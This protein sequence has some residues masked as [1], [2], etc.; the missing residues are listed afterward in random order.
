MLQRFLVAAL[1]QPARRRPRRSPGSRA[2]YE[3]LPASIGG[4]GEPERVWGQ[5]TTANFFDV[6]QLG[7]TLG[8]GFRSGEERL[9]VIVIGHGLW[10]RRFGADPAIAGKRI[11]LSGHP[12]T[13]VGVAPARFP[14]A[15]PGPRLPILGAARQPGSL[16]PN[17]GNYQSRD[18]HWITVAGRL[19]PA[20]RARRR[21]LNSASS[22]GNLRR[23][24]RRRRR[25]A[26]SVSSRP[27]RCR[28]ATGAPW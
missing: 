21:P 6:A 9:P 23:L 12:F 3:L 1:R 15:R 19:R 28:R 4:Q 2:Y 17:T 8:R 18:Y 16:L 11:A 13:V 27:V 20:S 14:R 22:R 25:T 5:A 7:M 24:T 26:A 10:Q